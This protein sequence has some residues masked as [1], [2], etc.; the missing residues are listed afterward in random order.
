MAHMDDV[1]EFPPGA[2]DVPVATIDLEHDGEAGLAASG[3]G[4]IGPLEEQLDCASPGPRRRHRSRDRAGAPE[5][6]GA[7]RASSTRLAARTRARRPL[8]GA[9]ANAL[10][11]S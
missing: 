9:T 1:V 4:L 11:A 3:L 7:G 6:G 5:N 2:V 10:R 8:I